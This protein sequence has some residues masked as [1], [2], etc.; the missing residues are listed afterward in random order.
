MGKIKIQKV[1]TDSECKICNSLLE[2]LIQFEAKLDLQINGNHRISDHYERTLGKQD[3][4]IFLAFNNENPVGYVIAYKQK[5]N[6]AQLR[7]VINVMNLYVKQEF[8][9]QN[10]G[11]TLINKVEKWAKDN[12]SN[13]D[14]EL[15]CIS[16]NENALKFYESLGFKPIRI[17]MRK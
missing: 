10:I 12:Y 14:I 17:R 5:E 7:N 13:Y 2:E 8:R 15:E 11:K 3:T 6:S 4:I 16:N 9:N 1:E